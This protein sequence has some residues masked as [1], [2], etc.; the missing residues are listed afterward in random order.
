MF[1]LQISD[2]AILDTLDALKCYKK[3]NKILSSRLRAE[4]KEV[5][6]L[7]QKNPLA[8]QKKYLNVHI[9]YCKSF[10]YAIHYILENKVIK[11]IAVFHTS[12]N[13]ENWLDRI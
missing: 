11:V 7:I 5:Y 2:V 8:F 1:T 13:P 6:V 9:C 10:P 4:I 3:R 12:R